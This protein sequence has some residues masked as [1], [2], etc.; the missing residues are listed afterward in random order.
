VST[1]GCCPRCQGAREHLCPVPFPVTVSTD[2]LP[3]A[4]GHRRRVDVV[5]PSTGTWPLCPGAVPP[6]IWPGTP[7]V[8]ERLVEIVAELSGSVPVGWAVIAPSTPACGVPGP[9]AG[10]LGPLC[11]RTRRCGAVC[12]GVCLRRCGADLACGGVCLRRHHTDDRREVAARST[13]P[14]SSPV[15]GLLSVVAAMSLCPLVAEPPLEPACEAEPALDV[16]LAEALLP[17]GRRSPSSVPLG[18]FGLG[19]IVTEK[20]IAAIA[21]GQCLGVGAR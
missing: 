19:E 18:C 20:G 4:R 2:V 3:G 9:P 16:V 8:R 10:V 21:A 12:G 14:T 17:S 13:K 7:A 15:H 11:R 6:G 5:E 1:D